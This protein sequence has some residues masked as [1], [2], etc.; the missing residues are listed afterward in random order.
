MT[1]AMAVRPMPQLITQY[2]QL[3]TVLHHRAPAVSLYGPLEIVRRNVLGGETLR[4]SCVKAADGSD[5][6]IIRCVKYTDAITGKDRFGVDYWSV[7]AY[8]TVDHRYRAMAEIAYVMAVLDE[9]AHPSL[10]SSPERFTRGLSGFY[11]VTDVI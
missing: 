2:G 4:E 1:L 8:W 9:F 3:R 5:D 11:D 6:L 7:N 10:P